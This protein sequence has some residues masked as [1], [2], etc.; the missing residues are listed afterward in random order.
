MSIGLRKPD[1]LPIVER[2]AAHADIVIETFRPGRGNGQNWHRLYAIGRDQPTHNRRLDLRLRARRTV[3]RSSGGT[4]PSPRPRLAWQTSRATPTGRL[5]LRSSQSPTTWPLRS[6][7][8]DL[9]CALRAR[10]RR[11]GRPHRHFIARRD[12]PNERR[13]SRAISRKRKDDQNA[14]HGIRDDVFVP[15]GFYEARTAG[16]SSRSETRQP[17][18]GSPKRWVAGTCSARDTSVGTRD[19]YCPMRS[20]L[21]WRLVRSFPSSEAVLSRLVAADVPCER[22]NDISQA[23]EHPQIRAR[24]IQ[25]LAPYR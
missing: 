6:R 10:A 16:S 19:R 7:R 24:D 20:T 23:I 14:P 9:R 11:A 18:G 1:A 5:R 15:W 3:C 12:L 2:L 21:P 13:R 8:S 22:V 25:Y 4:G 17:G